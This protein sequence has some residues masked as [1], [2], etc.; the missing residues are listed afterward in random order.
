MEA[1]VDERIMRRT[2]R[3]MKERGRELEGIFEQYIITVKPMNYLY[4]EPTRAL[5][6]YCY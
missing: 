1:D 3:D 6:R 2:I 5:A 4:V